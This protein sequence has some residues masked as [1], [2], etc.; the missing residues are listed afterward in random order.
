MAKE[1][2]ADLPTEKLIKRKKFV[3]FIIGICVGIFIIS[4][5]LSV[6]QFFK[7]EPMTSFIPGITVGIIWI[8]MYGGLK[9]INEELKRRAEQNI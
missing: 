4:L 3:F 8:P 1:N 7:G 6:I 2:I 5:A 9:K